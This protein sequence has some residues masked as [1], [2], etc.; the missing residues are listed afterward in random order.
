MTRRQFLKKKT[1]SEWP[2]EFF[3]KF[4]FQA[5][6]FFIATFRRLTLTVPSALCRALHSSP[7]LSSS[8]LTLPLY[9]TSL[10]CRP[11]YTLFPWQYRDTL[12][13]MLQYPTMDT[14]IACRYTPFV[15]STDPRRPTVS[16]CIIV[17]PCTVSV[18]SV[19]RW[20]N[21][22]FLFCFSVHHVTVRAF[23]SHFY[24]RISIPKI[25]LHFVDIGSSTSTQSHTQELES[26]LVPDSAL[27]V[28][29]DTLAF[30]KRCMKTGG[31]QNLLKS[32]WSSQIM[33]HIPCFIQI[34]YH[35]LSFPSSFL[36]S[37]SF[38]C[39]FTTT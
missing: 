33:Q 24:I 27:H 32:V 21:F 26:T 23:Q 35:H 12:R 20:D 38:T 14:G 25:L 39:N 29:I 22:T 16:H 15:S 19:Q 8:L 11:T 13:N 31:V 37:N 5:S 36:F 2:P 30:M 9:C 4:L 10:P 17:L 3:V 7:L 18:P 34:C 1:K 6:F 28:E